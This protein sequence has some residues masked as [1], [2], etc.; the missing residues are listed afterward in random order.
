M[1]F[2]FI[3]FYSEKLI[4]LAAKISLGAS[5]RLLLSVLSAYRNI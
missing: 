4:L 3:S 1:N 2:E 5:T